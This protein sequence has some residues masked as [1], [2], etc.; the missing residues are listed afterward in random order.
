MRNTARLFYRQ[1]EKRAKY[2][3]T[4]TN[5]YDSKKESNRAV[6]LKLMQKQGLI[7]DLREQVE[8]ELIPAQYDIVNGKKVCVERAA[9]YIADFVY[10]E[11]GRTIVEDVKSAATR[12]DKT[13]ILKRKLMLFVHGVRLKE[14]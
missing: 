3:N 8:Y 11:N 12:D 5:G 4:K 6:V 9:K 7:S 2:G 1:T 10:A 13:Y 14:A